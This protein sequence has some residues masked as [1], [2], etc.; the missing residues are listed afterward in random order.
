MTTMTPMPLEATLSLYNDTA[1]RDTGQYF[2]NSQPFAM[3]RT[4]NNVSLLSCGSEVFEG[5]HNAML[6]AESFIWIADWQMAFDVELASRG[7]KDNPG[8]LHNVIRH[9]ISTKKVHVRVLLY[10]SIVDSVPGTYDGM[11]AKRLNALNKDGYPGSVHVILQP[12]T[13]AQNDSHEYSHHQKF[14]VVDG[15]IGFIGGIDL[16]YGR[17]ETNEFD[18][19]VDPER[20]VINDM[21]SPGQTKMRGATTE[22]KQKIEKYDFAAPYGKCLIDEGCQP[23][24]PWQDVHI[25]IEG[26]SVVDIHRNFVRRWNSRLAQMEKPV[27]AP[28]AVAIVLAATTRPQLRALRISKQWLEKIGGWAR[29]TSAQP[30][31]EGGAQV[32]IVRS[33]STRHL[34]MEG[35]KPEDLLLYPDVRERA[36][37]ET[38][39]KAWGATHQSNILNAVVN[40]IRSA[41]NYIYIETQFFISQFGKVGK[42]DAGTIGNENDGMKNTVIDELA[43]R[44]DQHICAKEPAPFHVYL[45]FPTNP[46]GLMSDAAVW[47]QHWLALSTIK[48][49]SDSLIN[50]IK[51]SLVKKKRDPEEWVQYLTVLNMRNY[52]ATVMYARDPVTFDEDFSRE[53]GRYVVTEQIYI[54]SKLLI[55]DDAVAIVG[56]ANT[57]DRSLTGNGDSE[58]AAVVVDTEGVELRD[59]GSP[60]FKVQTR[61][62]ARELRQQLWKKHFGFLVSSTDKSS[63]YFMATTRA[64]RAKASV[65]TKIA[66]PPRVA[67]YPDKISALSGTEWQKILDKPCDPATVKAIQAIAQHNALIYEEVFQ[68]IPRNGMTTFEDIVN[69]KFHTVPYPP[70]YNSYGDFELSVLQRKNHESTAPRSIYASRDSGVAANIVDEQRRKEGVRSPVGD[71]RMRN[72][73]SFGGVVP[74]ALNR[75]FMTDTLLPHQEAALHESRYTRRQQLFADG[76][77]H[78]VETAIE[79]LKVNIVGFFVAAPLDWGKDHEIEGDPSKVSAGRV[80]IAAAAGR[81]QEEGHRS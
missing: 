47:Q 8:R 38:C 27:P 64:T 42:I 67:T 13:S 30:R 10:Q 9:I 78:D 35:V 70:V 55:V 7:L 2:C 66:H 57:N 15:H 20:Y 61:K 29:L 46:E 24:M 34:A 21:Y 80:D 53:I 59:L 37:W 62:F 50:R 73:V 44:I 69:L 12:S 49:G 19:V 1:S 16:S 14:V 77:V 23:R 51:R 76:T 52:G 36:M 25:K 58:I 48:H 26:P 79:Y 5:I 11:V 71:V 17:W 60:N 28:L 68:H 32:Q 6:A 45:V 54:H 33:V 39:L 75:K 43:K 65:P 74:P 81:A 22:E 3:P 63:R 41:D 18:V 40:C 56:S 4:G 31:K 72:G